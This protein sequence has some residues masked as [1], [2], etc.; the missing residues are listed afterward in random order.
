[1]P[2]ACTARLVKAGELGGDSARKPGQLHAEPGE[3]EAVGARIFVEEPVQVVQRA[4][5]MD[6][7]ELAHVRADL[8]H[9]MREQARR[10]DDLAGGLAQDVRAQGVRSLVLFGSIARREARPDSDVDLV[11]EFDRPVGYFA[12]FRLRDQLADWLGRPVDLA[13]ADSLRPELR[14][15]VLSEGLRAA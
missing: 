12:L 1:M 7:Q 11:V 8:I 3:H 6:H 4:P 9:L 14:Q 10:L 13:T 5:A 2:G 15:R